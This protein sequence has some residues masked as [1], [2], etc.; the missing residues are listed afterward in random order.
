MDAG[1]GT[2]NYAKYFLEYGIGVVSLLDASVAMMDKAKAKLEIEIKAGKIG[3]I[4]QATLP[5]IPFEDGT[6]DV[7]VFNT[8]SCHIN[9]TVMFEHKG[10][11]D[12]IHNSLY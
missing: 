11:C 2:G 9:I 12:M 3:S 1:C 4:V 6:F 7:V 5:E 10:R 8:V